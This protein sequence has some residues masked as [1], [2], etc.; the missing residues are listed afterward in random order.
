MDLPYA[1]LQHLLHAH[2]G[3]IEGLARPQADALRGALVGA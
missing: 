2:R 3:S 1:A